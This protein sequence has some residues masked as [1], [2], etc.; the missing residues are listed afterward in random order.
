MS[1]PAIKAIVSAGW[2]A[3]AVTIG[4]VGGVRS[5][6]AITML[7]ALGSLPPLALLL[8]WNDPGQTLS[9][10]IREGRR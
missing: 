4:L 1:L 6:G 8:L 9:E 3:T 7:A 2:I 10:S 5:S